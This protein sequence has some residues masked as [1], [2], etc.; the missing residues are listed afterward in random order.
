MLAN[1]SPQNE[2]S[3]EELLGRAIENCGAYVL[4]YFNAVSRDPN[5]SE[6]LAQDLWIYVY[7]S[8]DPEDF[9]HRGYLI[10]KARQI[11]IDKLRFLGRRPKI[12]FEEDSNDKMDLAPSPE[13]A[14]AEEETKLFLSFWEPFAS[15]ELTGLQKQI[16]WLHERYGMTIQEVAEKVGMAKSTAHDHLKTVREKCRRYLKQNSES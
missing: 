16:F 15:L 12:D 3:R 1:E 2:P 5:L 11:W 9:E 8:Y 6:E 4:A 7:K 13:P 14:N 10:N